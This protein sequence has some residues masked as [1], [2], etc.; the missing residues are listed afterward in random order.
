M[1]NVTVMYPSAPDRTFDMDY[2]L[3]THIPMAKRLWGSAL[4]D[5]RVSEG[6]GGAESGAKPAYRVI[7]DLVFD[8]VESFQHAYLPHAG[9]IAADVVN[10]TTI[11]PI[12]QVCAV[13]L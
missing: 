6:I 10:Y 3:T 12:I 7:C 4:K 2:Y 13:K 11:E 9:A 5:V 1:I 8:S